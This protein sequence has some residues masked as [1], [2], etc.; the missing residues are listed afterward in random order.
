[1]HQIMLQKRLEQLRAAQRLEARKEQSEVAAALAGQPLTAVPVVKGTVVAEEEEEDDEEDAE[2]AAQ[3]QMIPYEHAMSPEPFDG[4]G[5]EDRD[6]RVVDPEED[7]QQ[8]VSRLTSLNFNP[9][10]NP[11]RGFFYTFSWSVAR[12]SKRTSLYR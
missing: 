9:N 6:L 11:N 10:P 7:W 4:I 5:R 2:A 8:L 3:V 12:K 1:M